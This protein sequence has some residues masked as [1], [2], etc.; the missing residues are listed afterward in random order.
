MFFALQA[1]KRV[2]ET[3]VAIFGH[4]RQVIFSAISEKIVS[5]CRSA[6]APAFPF[7]DINPFLVDL[8]SAYMGLEFGN[9]AG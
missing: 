2:F 8:S 1:F 9:D 6:S 5:C 3:N 7:K 4:I